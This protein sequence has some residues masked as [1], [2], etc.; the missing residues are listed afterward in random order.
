MSDYYEELQYK[1]DDLESLVREAVQFI[2]VSA[3]ALEEGITIDGK[4]STAEEDAGTMSEIRAM[5]IWL[6]RAKIEIGNDND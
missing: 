4:L 6:A 5:R 2:Q 3:D 1:C